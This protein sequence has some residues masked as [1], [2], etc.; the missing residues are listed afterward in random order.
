MQENL[1]A[2]IIDTA[3]IGEDDRNAIQETM[4]LN[5]VPGMTES[6]LQAKNTSLE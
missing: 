3:I 4:N 2:I 1:N 6:L 5:S